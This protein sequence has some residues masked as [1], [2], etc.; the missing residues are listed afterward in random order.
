MPSEATLTFLKISHLITAFL[1]LTSIVAGMFYMLVR[2]VHDWKRIKIF[3][4]SSALTFIGTVLL[5]WLIYPVYLPDERAKLLDL[6]NAKS[7]GLFQ[8]KEHVSAL[9]VIISIAM[10]ALIIFGHLQKSSLQRKQLFASLYGT[11]AL[12]TVGLVVVAFTLDAVN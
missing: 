7:I 3:G 5:S 9:G 1:L 6:S 4:A 10:L 11:L 2:S 12:F 8:I